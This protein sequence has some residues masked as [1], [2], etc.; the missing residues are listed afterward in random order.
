MKVRS[1]TEDDVTV[2]V[3]F[4]A[5]SFPLKIHKWHVNL[6]CTACAYVVMI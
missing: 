1:D 5:I 4:I 6:M 2:L 3:S